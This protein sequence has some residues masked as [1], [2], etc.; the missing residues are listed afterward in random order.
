MFKLPIFV[1][2]YGENSSKKIGE[3]IQLVY[4]KNDQDIGF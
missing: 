4:A 3:K 2:G 1:I